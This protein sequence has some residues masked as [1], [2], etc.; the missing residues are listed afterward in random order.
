MQ[1]SSSGNGARDRSERPGGRSTVLFALSIVA[2]ISSSLFAG[3]MLRPVVERWQRPKVPSAGELALFLAHADVDVRLGRAGPLVE[4]LGSLAGEVKESA[5]KERV[6]ALWAEAALQVRRLE[7][8][9]IAESNREPLVSESGVRSGIRL[10]RIG[11]AVA[12][13]R[14]AE[15]EELAKPVLAG[16][17]ARLAD[18]ARLRLLPSISQKELR[19]WVAGKK[20]S[21]GED[22][23]RAGVAALRLLG[24]AGEAERLLA[25]LERE[26]QRDAG[27][28]EALG[29]VYSKLDR[30]KEVARVATALLELTNRQDQRAQ[31]VLVQAR[32]LGRAGE[33][34]GA[35]AAVEPLRHARGGEARQAG[36]RVHYELLQQA[37]RLQA[38]V[39]ALRDPAERAFVALEV[40]RN[41]AEA[42]RLYSVASRAHP[43]SLEAVEGLREAERRRELAERRSLYEQ[44]LKKE[45]EDEATR[46]KLLGLLVAL[47]EGEA[48]G[49]WI[50]DALRGREAKPEA[51]VATALALRRA[52]LGREAGTLLEKAH[53]VET[54]AAR[55]Q[56]ILFAL[57]DLYSET[58]QEEGARRL[59]ASLASDGSSAELRERAVARLAALLR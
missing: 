51:L 48:T 17:D 19:A 38:E 20:A 11:L 50:G 49:R 12:M 28:Y 39:G 26:G 2:V 30:P 54:D 52:G 31:L 59:Y 3:G 27:I 22:A 32:A 56:Q 43:D 40:E 46:G 33:V 7:D 36:R 25:P 8:A 35:L 42:V 14:G 10:R 5:T 24:D 15:A 23:R 44:V 47:G 34:D 1:T 58:R 18:E 16:G 45:P 37:G 55:K 29:E 53:A 9:A 6:L 4:T 21:D 57:G 13:G 41:Y